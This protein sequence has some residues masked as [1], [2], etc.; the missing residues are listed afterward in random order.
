MLLPLN[1]EDYQLLEMAQAGTWVNARLGA[2]DAQRVSRLRL[3][4]LIEAGPVRNGTQRVTTSAA[5]R[6]LLERRI[7][8]HVPLD[9][10][11]S[12]QPGSLSE[13]RELLRMMCPG[14]HVK[15]TETPHLLEIVTPPAARPHERD[16]L[17]QWLDD[18]L[19]LH[20]AVRMVEA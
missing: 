12:R 16:G 3:Q 5:G 15:R 13:L 14:V 6:D 20:F 4:G 18:N 7:L 11:Q 10:S 19:P 17:I 8:E 9:P 2:S 1:E